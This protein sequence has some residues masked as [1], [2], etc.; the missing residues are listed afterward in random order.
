MDVIFSMEKEMLRRNY[1]YRTVKTYIGCVKNFLN[2]CHV[3]QRKISKED[4]RGYLDNLVNRG[5]SGNTINVHLNAIG[6]L[7]RQ[8]LNKN[9][10]IKIKYSKVP[11]KIPVVLA[12]HEIISLVNCIGNKNHKLLIKLMYG[13]GL[14]VS[15]LISL[16]PENIEFESNFAWVRKGKGNKDRMFIIAD[17]LKKE[18][19]NYIEEN[20][21]VQKS[22]LFPGH[23]GHLSARTVQ[24]IVKKAAKKAKIKKNVHPHALRHSYATHLIENGYDLMSVQSLLGHNSPQTTLIYLHIARMRIINVKSPLDGLDFNNEKT[25]DCEAPKIRVSPFINTEYA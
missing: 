21:L 10:M 11:K 15:E 14:R 16:K 7:V 8:I 2:F 25:P 1:S 22:W 19:L 5:S 4:V 13:A 20:S 24:E 6:F 17:C 23:N 12:K 9:F 3:E 18:L